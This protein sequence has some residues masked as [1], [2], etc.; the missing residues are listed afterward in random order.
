MDSC[1]DVMDQGDGDGDEGKLS[2]S[3]TICFQCKRRRLR[4]GG[5]LGEHYMAGN[6]DVF[7]V[8]GEG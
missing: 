1:G 6:I 3:I 2:A 8:F 7:E 5:F 4:C